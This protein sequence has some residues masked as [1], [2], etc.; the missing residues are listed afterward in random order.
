MTKFTYLFNQKSKKITR[1]LIHLLV[2]NTFLNC[3]SNDYY[4][5]GVY[6]SKQ[7]NYKKSIEY[8]TKSI[9]K[10]PSDAEA[11]YNRAYF[12]QILG[13]NEL[14]VIS[15]YTSSLKLKPK[16]FEAYMNRGVA[17]MKIG[18]NKEAIYDYKKSIEINPYSAIVYE[19][20]GNAYF[21]SFSISKACSCW[22]KSL[23]LGNRSIK[24]KIDMHCDNY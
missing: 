15:D 11:Y 19:N 9:E 24:D 17:K 14:Q 20:L 18:M 10:N 5:L 1:W 16:D 12:Q 13:G 4:N 23:K 8:F 3:E 21:N 2:F 7:G 6:H 22:R